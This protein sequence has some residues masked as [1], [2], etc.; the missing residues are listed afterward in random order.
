MLTAASRMKARMLRSL[1]PMFILLA[2]SCGTRTNLSPGAANGSGGRDA[3]MRDASAARDAVVERDDADARM[4]EPA[5]TMVEWMAALR[6]FRFS[7]PARST[8]SA[9]RR[10]AA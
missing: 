6:A 1:V 2:L 4:P 3:G 10:T 8:R 9:A 5:V 7:M